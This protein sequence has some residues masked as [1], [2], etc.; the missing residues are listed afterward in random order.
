[1]A[2]APSKS[3]NAAVQVLKQTK[4]LWDKQPKGRRTLAVLI[5]LGVLGFVAITTIV[6]KTETWT[7][8]AEGMAPSDAQ[9][10][11]A[12]LIGRGINARMRDGLVEVEGDDLGQARAIATLSASSAG[13]SSMEKE[14]TGDHI[15]RT[16]F[17]E[18][19]AYKRGLEGELS[20]NIIAL[21]ELSSARVTIAFGKKSAVKDMEM[22]ATASVTVV[23]RAGRQLSPDHVSGIRAMVA[24]SVDARRRRG[25]SP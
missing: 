16:S 1:M 13:L 18:Q 17:D 2:D 24:A 4:E 20:R 12:T 23:P 10:I 3:Q 7:A 14:F 25:G 11:Y 5:V 6:K 9:A 8:I 22:P 19:V 21:A 15:G